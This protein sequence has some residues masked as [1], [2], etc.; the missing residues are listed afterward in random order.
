MAIESPFVEG[1]EARGRR[2]AG[3]VFCPGVRVST[4]YAFPL[5]SGSVGATLARYRALMMM[6]RV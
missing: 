3:E 6:L 2:D 5:E 1:T 4:R